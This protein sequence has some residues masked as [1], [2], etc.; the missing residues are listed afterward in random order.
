M[1]A[2]ESISRV[3]NLVG[4]Y[5]TINIVRLVVLIKRA[6]FATESTLLLLSQSSHTL[7]AQI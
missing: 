6:F 7:K 4:F 1:A 5:P 3:G 2:T